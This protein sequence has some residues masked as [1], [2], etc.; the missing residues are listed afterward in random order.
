[1]ADILTTGVHE[2]GRKGFTA[3]YFHTP[4]GLAEE[5]TAAGLTDVSLHSVE[6]PALQAARGRQS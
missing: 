5:M 1:M 2:P 6:G 3:A 4:A